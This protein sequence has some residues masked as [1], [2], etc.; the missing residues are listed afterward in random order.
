MNNP[1]AQ[2]AQYYLNESDRLSEELNSE[3]E[4]SAVLEEVLEE[5]VGT[6]NFLK[7]MEFYMPKL[8]ASS[9]HKVVKKI[10]NGKEFE[11]RVP[12]TDA[13]TERYAHH[14]GKI[15]DIGDRA[16]A[17]AAASTDQDQRAHIGDLQLRAHASLMAH[18][19]QVGQ[20]VNNRPAVVHFDSNHIPKI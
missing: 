15:M 1:L 17:A 5:L 10:V 19:G 11:T 6:E 13:E 2:R 9:T 8:G 18:G 4:Y 20:D 14:L 16:H 7:I 3:V 12:R